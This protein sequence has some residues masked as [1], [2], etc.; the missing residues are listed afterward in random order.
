[1]RGNK[2][3][4]A[5]LTLGRKRD[6]DP[7]GEAVLLVPFALTVPVLSPT[8]TPGASMS[9]IYLF[10]HVECSDLSAHPGPK[11]QGEQLV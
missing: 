9:D 1:V 11:K 3:W 10:I 5:S 2:I 8:P 4:K 6:I 7:T